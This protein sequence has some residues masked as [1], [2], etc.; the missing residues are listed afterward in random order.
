VHE[1]HGRV[2]PEG[3]LAIPGIDLVQKVKSPKLVGFET[4]GPG[5]DALAAGR[6]TRS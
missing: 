3:T 5:L 1:L 6:S 4:E 2:V